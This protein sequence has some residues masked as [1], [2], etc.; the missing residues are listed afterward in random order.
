MTTSRSK[1]KY[2]ERRVIVSS[3]NKG[4]SPFETKTRSNVMPGPDGDMILV[5]GIESWVSMD[6]VR[7][8]DENLQ[9]N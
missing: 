2:L 4:E 1:K 8:L 9:S 5:V 3:L 6:R 7:F